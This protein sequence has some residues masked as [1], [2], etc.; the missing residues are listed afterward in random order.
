LNR[1]LILSC[2]GLQLNCRITTTLRT[3]GAHPLLA[4]C[5]GH[6]TRLLVESF[7]SPPICLQLHTVIAINPEV[8][9]ISLA[10]AL[11]I[12]VFYKHLTAQRFHSHQESII[13]DGS[14]FLNNV[15]VVSG[16]RLP[17]A[18]TSTIYSDELAIDLQT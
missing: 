3:P 13:V 15:V 10:T 14:N 9:Y 12:D 11:R 5:P 6:K 7:S 1:F 16:V 17:F 18:M 2:N 4:N 8:Q